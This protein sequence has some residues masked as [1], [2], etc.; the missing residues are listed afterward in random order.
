MLAHR[1]F[2]QARFSI[3]VDAKAQ[4]RRDPLAV[5]EALLWRPPRAELAISEHGARSCVFEEGEA[6]VAKR[7]AQPEE[8]AAQLF[9]YKLEGLPENLTLPLL[10]G[11]KGPLPS[12]PP[13]PPCL[14]HPPL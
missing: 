12:P 8:V 13:P 9:Q 5:L 14:P 3:W 6:I 10:Q 7:K 1:L 4:F 11:H 2:P